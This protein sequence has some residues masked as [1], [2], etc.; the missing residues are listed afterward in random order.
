ME[1]RIHS[2]ILCCAFIHQAKIM[3]LWLIPVAVA[4]RIRG[5]VIKQP[6]LPLALSPPQNHSFE[7]S[8]PFLM[9][10]YKSTASC[11][12]F[13]ADFIVGGERGERRRE[14]KMRERY[15]SWHNNT[16][17]Q[18]NRKPHQRCGPGYT[19]IVHPNARQCCQSAPDEAR[20][21]S[22]D[23]P[24]VFEIKVGFSNPQKWPPQTAL[25]CSLVSPR[26]AIKHDRNTERYLLADEL[27]GSASLSYNRQLTFLPL[28]LAPEHN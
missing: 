28:C 4:Q 16:L 12:A 19:M 23:T 15:S 21:P 18:L 22:L 17:H 25:A 1:E 26:L 27:I 6:A 10:P 2:D 24:L 8:P 14:Q 5:V 11:G 7:L 3:A 13:P 9:S 20:R